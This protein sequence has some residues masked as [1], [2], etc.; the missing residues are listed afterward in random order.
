MIAIKN[1]VV[2]TK[3]TTIVLEID[4]KKYKE[5]STY[6]ASESA[7]EDYLGRTLNRKL[8]KLFTENINKTVEQLS[9]RLS[10]NH[11]KLLK[12]VK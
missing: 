2:G 8:K 10:D 4:M 11:K 7:F 6:V 5:N 9:K 12:G 3:I 1:H